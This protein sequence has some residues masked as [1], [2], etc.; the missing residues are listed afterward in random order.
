MTIVAGDILRTTV[1][2]SITGGTLY[3]NVFHHQRTGIGILSDAVHV[4]A[5]KDWAEAMYA[6]IEDRVKATVVEQLSFVDIVEF[7]GGVWTVTE[8]IGTFVPVFT[9]IGTFDTLPNQCS[10]FV[11]FKTARPK[12]VGR[13]FLF[14]YTEFEQ[15]DSILTASALAATVAWASDALNNIVIQVLDDL[16]PGIVRTGVDSFLTFTVAVVTDLIGTQR[17]RRIGE[18][19]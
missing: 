6:E 5:I 13:K 11:I 17:R 2:F 10:P 12:S 7:V 14:P 18:G 9:P 19:A 1:N 3:Q 8:N 16:V 4:Q 15:V